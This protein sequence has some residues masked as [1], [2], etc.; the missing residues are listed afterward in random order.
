MPHVCQYFEIKHLPLVTVPSLCSS[1]S[2]F[3][4]HRL[5][6]LVRGQFLPMVAKNW[7]DALDEWLSFIIAL[8]IYYI[9][10]IFLQQSALYN[11]ITMILT[12]STNHPLSTS[13]ASSKALVV[14]V[15][16]TMNNIS[17]SILFMYQDS[18]EMYNYPQIHS[19]LFPS[20]H[21]HHCRYLLDCANL[22]TSNRNALHWDIY[23]CEEAYARVV[24][25]FSSILDHF[26]RLLVCCWHH[27]PVIMYSH[28]L[29]V[30]NSFF[31]IDQ[32][33]LHANNSLRSLNPPFPH[34]RSA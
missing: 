19:N 20:W 8:G 31:D 12:F 13:L 27:V 6:Y 5:S 34:S 9:H 16:K 7:R 29:R 30:Y 18:F 1:F 22:F 14:G 21:N 4:S 3:V 23:I 28:P 33:L 26:Y 11:I 24:L 2:S 10:M 25:P 32:F 15:S 17:N